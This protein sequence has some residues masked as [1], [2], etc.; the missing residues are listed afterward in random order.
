LSAC[1]FVLC[2]FFARLGHRELYSS[3]EARAAQNAQ[4]MLDTGEWGLPVLFD[5]RADLQKPS[6]YYWAVAAVGWLHH[7]KVTEWVA[8]APSALAG[9]ACVLLVYWFLWAERRPRAA[10]IAALVL[11]T[12]T[13]FT[14]I[15]RTA[16]IDVPL[17]CAVTVAMLS[18]YRGCRRESPPTAMGGLYHVLAALAAAVALLLKGPVG[19]ALIGPAALAWLATERMVLRGDP[20]RLRV[21]FASWM[22]IPLVVAAVA[23]PWFVWANQATDGEFFRVFFW[24]H[25]IDRY[26]GN[27][28]LLATHPPLYYVPRFAVDFLPW[29]PVLVGLAAWALHTGRCRTDPMLR[30]G[31]VAFAVMFVVLSTARFKRAD[32]LLPAYP[33]AAVVL[34]CAG[35]AWLASR[36]DCRAVRVG[37]WAFGGAVAAAAVTWLVMTFAVEPAEQAKE[38]KRR[39][40]AVIRTYAPAPQTILQFRME[41]HLLS[42]HLGRPLH[43][44]VE[45]GELDELLAAPGPHFVVMP[46]EY[47]YAAGEIVKSRKLV[48]VARLENY[49]ADKPSRPL[50]FLRT[51]D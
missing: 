37:K 1:L 8:R 31:L 48:V 27:S 45:W 22:L 21:P 26:T 20:S 6:G 19:L 36:G 40:A 30:F 2:L 15:A 23:L 35:E 16:R 4:R 24:H 44:L 14:G 47:V 39:F 12:A 38:E 43:T 33:F 9:F 42:Y 46:P 50:V 25:T 5:G 49:T 17:A 13:H 3:H 32:Y 18:F 7:G 51:A 10:I 34:G 28:P 11:A 41:S 29:T